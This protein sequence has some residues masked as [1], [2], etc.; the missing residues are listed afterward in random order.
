MCSLSQY[1]QS[2]LY[3]DYF[4]KSINFPNVP[5]IAHFKIGPGLAMFQ[6][7]HPQSNYKINTLN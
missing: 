4:S 1:L 3:L 6:S 5:A 2:T 7:F